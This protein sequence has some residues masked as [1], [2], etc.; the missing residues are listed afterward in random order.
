MTKKIEFEIPDNFKRKSNQTFYMTE[1]AY[2]YL[3]AK[4]TIDGNAMG[5]S[6]DEMVFAQPDFVEVM[7]KF[8]ENSKPKL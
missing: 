5:E 4:K 3:V 7:H 1:Y 2:F 8:F 6:I